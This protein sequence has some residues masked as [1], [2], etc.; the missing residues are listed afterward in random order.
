MATKVNYQILYDG[1]EIENETNLNYIMMSAKAYAD[2]V[3]GQHV[4]QVKRLSD[5]VIIY[6]N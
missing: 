4:I 2:I 3:K 6:Q 1:M 5:N